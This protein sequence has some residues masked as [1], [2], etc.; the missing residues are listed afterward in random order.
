M[1]LSNVG[2]PA[3]LGDSLRELCARA[4]AGDKAAFS[5]LHDRL[6]NGLRRFLRKR[7]GPREDLVD[8]LV[9]RAWVA[10]WESLQQGRYDPERAAFTTFLYG[11]G[12]KLWLQQARISSVASYSHDELDQF[13]DAMFADADPAQFLR[14]CELLETVRSCLDARSGGGFSEEEREVLVGISRGESEREMGAR[15]GLAPSTINVRKRIA[16]NKLRD[17]LQRSGLAELSDPATEQSRGSG[18]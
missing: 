8:E 6:A 2:H 15:L 14:T 7:A 3:P 5:H 13:A 11:I 1:D 4:A 17:Y 9:Q 10:A 12:Y 16:I 18:E